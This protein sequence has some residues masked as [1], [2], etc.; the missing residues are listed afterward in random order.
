MSSLTTSPGCTDL[1]ATDISIVGRSCVPAI[2]PT[3]NTIPSTANIPV[4]QKP[5]NQPSREDEDRGADDIALI[6]SFSGM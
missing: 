3:D 4:A 6:L 5:A 1:A 2:D